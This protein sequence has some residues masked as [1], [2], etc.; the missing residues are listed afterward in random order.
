MQDPISKTDT[1]RDA[2]VNGGY[3][4]NPFLALV[5]APEVLSWPSLFELSLRALPAG[6]FYNFN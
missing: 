2:L 5:L 4:E 6:A 3:Q 1:S